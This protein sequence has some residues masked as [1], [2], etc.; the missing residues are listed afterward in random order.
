MSI[1]YGKH[2]SKFRYKNEQVSSLIW[3]LTLSLYLICTCSQWCQTWCRISHNWEQ[4]KNDGDFPGGRR[5]SEYADRI[6][7]DEI[8]FQIID[9]TFING[10]TH[11]MIWYMG[12]SLRW[13]YTNWIKRFHFHYRDNRHTGNWGIHECNM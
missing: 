7:S 5:G 8:L 6:W 11:H 4:P 13:M 3:K 9:I 12:C 1:R 2:I 10:F